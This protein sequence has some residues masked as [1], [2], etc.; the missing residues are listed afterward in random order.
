M[1]WYAVYQLEDGSLVSGTNDPL[2][3]ASA[4]ILEAR[5]YG[6]KQ[7]DDGAQA[8]I[9]NATTLVFD[10]APPTPVLID[11][12]T[13]YSLFSMVERAKIYAST[14]PG[15]VDYIRWLAR[16]IAPFDLL[17]DPITS[18]LSYLASIG[19]FDDQA[20]V[21]NAA[22]TRPAAIQAWKGL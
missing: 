2:K 18:G 20:G 9:W 13:F 21:A 22:T 16:V 5:G 11:P 6:V 1:S 12:A 4:A 14:D 17:G 3:I 7:L 19:I 15:V 8:G 10:P